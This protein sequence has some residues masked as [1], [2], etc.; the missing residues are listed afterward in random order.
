MTTHSV[1]DE[2]MAS[3][4]PPYG[5]SAHNGVVFTGAAS[6]TVERYR[7]RGG[8]IA[9]PELRSRQPPWQAADQRAGRAV[10]D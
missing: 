9:T 6:V 5:W 1:R 3:M 2:F 10:L 7:Y 8:N 4:V